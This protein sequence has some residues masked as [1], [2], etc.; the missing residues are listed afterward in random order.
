MQHPIAEA[1]ATDIHL[2]NGE[3][4]SYL[5]PPG[6]YTYEVA[7]STFP[8]ASF[9]PESKIEGVFTSVDKGASHYGVVP[10]ENSTHGSV[11]QT[12]DRLWAQRES[13]QIVGQRY[14]DV[15]HSL[16]VGGTLGREGIR[17][18]YS[19]PQALGQCRAWLQKNLP[20]ADVC[21]VASTGHAAQ[22]AARET[23]AA[24]IC[25]S[26]CADMYGLT[27]LEKSIEDK[28]DNVTRFFVIKRREQDA[29]S[30]PSKAVI[31]EPTGDMRSLL[32]FTCDSRTTLVLAKV[33]Q[34]FDR[35]GLGVVKLEPKPSGIR[36]WCVPWCVSANR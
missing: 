10:F 16:M 20:N 14:F 4:V 17:K 22:L 31:T 5:G 6:T 19:H 12:L 23:D 33:L 21:S 28:S 8:A 32:V 34:V 25:G 9:L 18:V 15:H 13:I 35:Y 7:L 24:A 3:I 36:L 30:L 26:V 27:V 2:P 29:D 11:Q 1:T